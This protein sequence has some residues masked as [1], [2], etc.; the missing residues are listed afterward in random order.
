MGTEEGEVMQPPF[1]EREESL[2]GSDDAGESPRHGFQGDRAVT[3]PPPMMPCGLTIAL[4]REAGARG[5]AIGRRIGQKLGWQVFDQELLEYMAQDGVV[6]QGVLDNLKPAAAV[7]AEE[8][9]QQLLRE[10]NLSQN[11][12]ILTLAR[13]VLAL[14][15]QGEAVMIGRGSGFILPRASTL[16]VRLTAPLE[17]R[18]AYMSQWQRLPVGEAAEMVRVRDERRVEFLQTHFHRHGG[19]VHQYDMLLNTLMLGEDVCAELIVTAARARLAQM[20]A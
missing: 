1:M 2:A 14:G 9:L 3:L 13:V 10:Q 12:A 20:A 5:G 6:R 15:A 7:W 4:S 16:H 19:D 17:E 18:I 8:R 11:P